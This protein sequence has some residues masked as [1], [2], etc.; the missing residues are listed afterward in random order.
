MTA[1]RS[2]EKGSVETLSAREGFR[3]LWKEGE[4]YVK[5]QGPQKQGNS[6]ESTWLKGQAQEVPALCLG[7]PKPSLGPSVTFSHLDG[8]TSHNELQAPK[9]CSDPWIPSSTEERLLN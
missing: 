6:R 4:V 5:V 2:A 1:H 9:S 7:T 3:N 8:Q